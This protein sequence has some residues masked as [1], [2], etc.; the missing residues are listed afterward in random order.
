[1]KSEKLNFVVFDGKFT[2]ITGIT[3][4]YNAARRVDFP[5]G[6]A[7][8]A[9]ELVMV[10]SERSDFGDSEEVWRINMN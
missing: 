10:V 1:M 7:M 6:G 4:S 2:V 8:D 9:Y 5:G 3:A